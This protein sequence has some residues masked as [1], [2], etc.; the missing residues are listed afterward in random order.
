MFIS[1]SQSDSQFNSNNLSL[2][3]MQGISLSLSFLLSLFSWLF[4]S[5]YLSWIF[6]SSFS[7]LFFVFCFFQITDF[8]YDLLSQF[9]F[10]SFIFIIIILYLLIPF[11][12]FFFILFP[13]SFFFLF[14]FNFFLI[15]YRLFFFILFLRL[16]SY[17]F[18][19]FFFI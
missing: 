16:S 7:V 14:F 9:S 4:R 3:S 1:T 12:I 10:F 2:I 11:N 17:H 15:F 18:S 13:V 19:N 6:F 5:L 8:F